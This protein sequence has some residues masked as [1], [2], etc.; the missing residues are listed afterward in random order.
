MWFYFVFCLS[1]CLFV[2]CL[3][4]VW[5]VFVQKYS[6]IVLHIHT[7]INK[8]THIYIYMYIFHSVPLN[9]LY[10]PG[11]IL[12]QSCLPNLHKWS[13][14]LGFGLCANIFRAQPRPHRPHKRM[15]NDSQRLCFPLPHSRTGLAAGSRCTASESSWW[16]EQRF[17]FHVWLALFLCICD[18][19]LNW[20][21]P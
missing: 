12:L 17:T 5:F 14:V 10:S 6:D 19:Q 11:F 7:C 20:I 21:V 3:F 13:W 18:H 9:D 4:G 16:Q 2:V 1:V 8:H 15:G